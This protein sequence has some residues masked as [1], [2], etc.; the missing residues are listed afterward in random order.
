MSLLVASPSFSSVADGVCAHSL[1]HAQ[2]Q[3]VHVGQF[4]PALPCAADAGRVSLQGRVRP[5][6][7]AEKPALREVFLAK[8]PQSFYVDFGDFR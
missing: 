1:G 4:V 2:P 5:V 6:T 3:R 7:E 8:H